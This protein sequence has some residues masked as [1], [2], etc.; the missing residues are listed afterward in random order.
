[1]DLPLLLAGPMLRRVDPGLV[2]VQIVLSQPAV[3]KLTVW[4]GRVAHNTTNPAF[5]SSDDPHD[6]N[7]PPPRPGS[8]TVRLG[9]KLHLGLVSARLPPASGKVFQSDRLYSY[10]V[11]IK[12]GATTVDLAGL[13]LLGEHTVSGVRAGPL[14]YD[15]RMLPSFALPPTTLDDLQLA[16]GSC[17]RPSY[18][19][20]DALAWM[21]EYLA[22]RV[23]DPRA[24][25]HQLFLGGDQIYADDVA[26]LMM[27]RIAELGVELIGTASG[28]AV[29]RVKVGQVKKSTGVAPDPLKPD[30]AYVDETSADA[31]QG[32]L[33]AGAPAFPVSV[34][35][36]TAATADVQ[37]GRLNLTTI[38]AQFTSGDGT[39]HLISFGEFAATYLLVWSPACWGVEIP[40]AQLRPS[41]GAPPLAGPL[42]WLDT[43]GEDQDIAYP[44]PVFP[45][46]IP[47]HLFESA[48]VLAKR[49]ESRKKESAA[50]RTA[51]K[52]K[53]ARSR[54]RS[55]RVHREFLLGLAKVQRVLANVPTYMIMDDHDLTDDF[56]LNPLWRRRVLGSVLGQVIMTNGMLAYALFQDWGNDPRRYDQATTPDRPELGGLLP[57]DL[58][59]RAAEL[60]PP[61]AAR[62]PN[63][64]A[65]ATLG[66]M[67]GH[68]LDNPPLPDGRFGPVKPP[69]TWHFSVD[70]PK[71][72]VVA[73]DNRTRRSF[74]AEIG[75]PGNV[76]AAAL[77]DQVPPPPLP[78]GREV[79]IVIA[80]LQVIGPPVIDEVVARAIYRVFDLLDASELADEN[81]P[82]GK[83]QMPGTNPDA[84]E[85]WAFDAISY[86]HLLARLA[87]YGR[88]VLLSGDVHNAASNA[89]S[90]WRGAEQR[91]ARLVQFTSSGFKNVMPV[92]LRALDASAMLLQQLLRAHLGVERLGWSRPEADLVLLPAGLTESDLVAS[93]RAKL[94]RS[95]V[96]LPTHGWPD[97][98]RLN[99]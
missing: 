29:E 88:V 37:F 23:G 53:E 56:F 47:Q 26:S 40:G 8:A 79:L 36:E 15:D 27:L 45:S 82:L 84:L 67:F 18:D 71:H 51:R 14:G 98:S 63:P 34:L 90:Y 65:F 64:D 41:V 33:P 6:P 9:E 4:E 69:I 75:P 97:T 19:D 28:V 12:A 96:L 52:A 74:A 68:D 38:G 95:P 49:A 11:S 58:L 85:T 13:G 30:A 83:R 31:A 39:N 2:A 16:Y 93:T 94:L 59:L 7:S 35:G 86:E 87:E 92:Y 78:A 22:E 24:R 43:P 99:P 66:R 20:G 10:N 73:L 50:D 54:L 32:D 21:D 70:G 62:G 5:A 77:V 72:R 25:I 60:F 48:T 91:P 17:R 42:R 57:G 44:P 80:P 1:M 81:S 3:V 46:R 76:S 61:G 89:M 55:H